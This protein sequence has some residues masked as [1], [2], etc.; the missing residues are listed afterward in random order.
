MKCPK[1]AKVE[2]IPIIIPIY[3]NW[4]VKWKCPFCNYEQQKN[5]DVSTTDKTEKV[6]ES[7]DDRD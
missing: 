7:K 5:K 3:N 4:Q 2:M 6:E 1:C